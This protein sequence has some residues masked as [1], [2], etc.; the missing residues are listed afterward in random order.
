MRRTALITGGSRGLGRALALALASGGYS[1]AINYL[2]SDKEA[3]D[4]LRSI[5]EALLLKADVSDSA[6]VGAMASEIKKKWG[7]LDVLINNAGVTADTLLVKLK[8]EDWDRVLGT[9]LKG[10]FNTIKAFAPLM[11]ESGGG[12]IINISSISGT[13]GKAGQAAYS[14]SKAAVLGL[15]VSAAREL[16]EYNIRVNAV[17]PGY[18]PTDMGRA[19]PAAM[20]MARD[21]S[22]I[23]KLSDPKE[24]A[25]FIS[26]LVGTESVTGQVFTID[27]RV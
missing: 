3:E 14:A 9:N 2:K 20:D 23:G 18:M 26:W 24:V 10:C 6:A 8:E 22:L 4:V 5:G 15:T 25:S 7:R 17:L 13:R 19:G 21:E 11:K 12:H 27:S 16:S 1:V